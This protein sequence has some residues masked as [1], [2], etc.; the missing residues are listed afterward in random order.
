MSEKMLYREQKNKKQP[1]TLTSE[2]IEEQ[3]KQFLKQGGKI[4][5]VKTGTSG[6]NP[7]TKP[8]HLETKKDKRKSKNEKN[9]K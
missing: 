2:E 7:I 8:V 5:K 4:K 3:T 1:A 6:L 9:N